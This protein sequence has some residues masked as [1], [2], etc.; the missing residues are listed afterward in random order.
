M[1]LVVASHDFDSH[2]TM[3]WCSELNIEVTHFGASNIEYAVRRSTIAAQ[4]EIKCVS[5]ATGSRCD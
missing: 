1:P 5:A 3:G 2:P 4:R